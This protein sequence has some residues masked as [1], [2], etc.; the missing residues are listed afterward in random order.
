MMARLTWLAFL[1]WLLATPALAGDP[2]AALADELMGAADAA[3]ARGVLFVPLAG[4]DGQSAAQGRMLSGRILSALLARKGKTAVL[5]KPG[6]AELLVTG[7]YMVLRDRIKTS[8]RLVDSGTGRVLAAASPEFKNEWAGSLA[9]LCAPAP[10]SE[11]AF[12]APLA[13]ERL[14]TK[15]PAP[16]EPPTAAEEL[17]QGLLQASTPAPRAR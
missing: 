9:L 6:S 17:L 16:G 5:L 3:S 1:T 4:A 8:L 7:D 14:A 2:Y 12:F 11:T 10:P 15:A 13:P